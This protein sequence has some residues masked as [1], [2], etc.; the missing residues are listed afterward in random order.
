MKRVRV[1]ASNL[2][3]GVVELDD[4]ASH[5][6]TRVHRL[7][8]GAFLELFDPDSALEARAVLV[9]PAT[10]DTGALV[11]VQEV[12][13][14]RD[15]SIPLTLAICIS[16]NDKPEQA[17]RDAT[18]LGARAV[19]LLA[20]DRVQGRRFT[21]DD[22]RFRKVM[23]DSARQSGRVGLPSVFGPFDMDEWVRESEGPRVVL[24]L[25]P[26]ARP[27]LDVLR[28]WQPTEPVTLLVGPEGGLT[29][30]ELQALGASGFESASIGPL[31]LRAETAV[32]VALGVARVR[33]L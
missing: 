32:T 30:L 33:A 1:F 10:R 22:A 21:R 29:G 26:E 18:V 24:S 4:E 6:V 3:R 2:S 17:L 31:V 15:Q 16:K 25:D 12:E 28:Q 5:Y 11:E 7:K 23:L 8:E 27:L 14:A 19:V 20:S 9:R 13:P